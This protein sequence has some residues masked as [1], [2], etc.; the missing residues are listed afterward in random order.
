[1]G[2]RDGTIERRSDTQPGEKEDG[3]Q[4]SR[5]ERGAAVPVAETR[6]RHEKEDRR[7]QAKE[8]VRPTTARSKPDPETGNRPEPERGP[9]QQTPARAE[10]ESDGPGETR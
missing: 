1:E 7:E 9:E 6:H 5:P 8:A 10:Q 4:I 2:A 3:Q